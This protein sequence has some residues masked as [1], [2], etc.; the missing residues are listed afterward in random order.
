MELVRDLSLST[1][2]YQLTMA[3]G[4]YKSGKNEKAVF[5]LFY[6]ENPCDNGYSIFC[7]LNQVIEYI[8]NLKFYKDDLN[9]LQKQGFDED[10]L[11]Y[12]REF[13][14]SGNLYSIPEGSIIFPQEPV[15]K[16]E[17]PIIEAQLLETPLLNILN[18][19]SLIAT[20]ASR[21]VKAAGDKSVLEFGL[22]RAHGPDAGLYGARAA[23]IGGFSG[24]SNVLAGKKFAINISG[25]HAHSWVMSFD[26]EL[27]AF[28]TYANIYPD[29]CILLVDTYDTLNKGVPNA[30]KVFQEMKE[31]GVNSDL[32]GIR[33]DSGDLARLSRQA[34]KM[35]DKAGFENAKI[36]ASGNLDENIITDLKKENAEIDFYGVGTKLIT[37]YNCSAFGGV[38]KLSEYKGQAKMKVSDNIEKTSNPGNKKLIRIYDKKSNKMVKDII[39]LKEENLEFDRNRY[40]VR[41]M[42][43]PIF[44]KG[45]CRYKQAK[46]SEIQQYCIEEKQTLKPEYKLL[47]KADIMEVDLSPGLSKLK[48]DI[49][50]SL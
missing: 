31:K 19:Q 21:V 6:R 48:Q 4:Y 45:N 17:A 28:R 30:I 40:Q 36:V 39:A 50:S 8:D 29:S 7:G 26:T 1:D 25:T 18:H 23:V 16:V 13:S 3:Q 10:F 27:E 49:I 14:F 38:Y 20:K 2:L 43:E 44:K 9:Y 11:D 15:L 46:V 34:R 12:L 32:Y 42:L 33:L 37:S 5:D 22:R 24:T 35:L 47:A 41:E